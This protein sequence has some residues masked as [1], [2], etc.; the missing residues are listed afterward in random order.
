MR[1]EEIKDKRSDD[2][3]K[4]KIGLPQAVATIMVMDIVFSIDSVITAV[5]LAE[6]LIIMILAVMIAVILMMVFIDFISDFINKNIEMKILALTFIA[7]IGILLVFDALG[8]T[9]GATILD[10]HAEKAMVYFAMV[11]SVLLAFL[12]L[13]YKSI[14]QNYLLE[15]GIDEDDLDPEDAD[16]VN[17]PN[18]PDKVAPRVVITENP[19]N[20]SLTEDA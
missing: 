3:N 20:G 16:D 10:M 19:Q 11:F 7:A 17:V 9:S 14:L 8:I 4:H 15:E 12:Q 1:L 2:P 5:G 13:K 6:H 18:V